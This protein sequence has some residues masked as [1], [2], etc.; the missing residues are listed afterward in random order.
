MLAQMPA[1]L[2][3]VVAA[4]RD[5]LAADPRSVILAAL[6]AIIVWALWPRSRQKIDLE[7]LAWLEAKVEVYERGLAFY[8]TPALYETLDG[9]GFPVLVDGGR[10]A[11][12]LLDAGT[13]QYS[14]EEDV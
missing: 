5:W 8:A 9:V 10:T 2:S 7:Y 11:R 12:E 1:M 13:V 3:H 4:L 14:E 6:A